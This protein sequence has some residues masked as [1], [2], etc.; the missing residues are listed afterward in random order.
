MVGKVSAPLSSTSEATTR[1][2][3]ELYH[4]FAAAAAERGFN[5]LVVEGPGQVGALHRNP[6]LVMRPDYEVPIS[7]VVDYLVTRPDVDPERLAIVGYP[8]GGYLAPRAAAFAELTIGV[9]QAEGWHLQQPAPGVLQ[10][11]TPCGRMLRHRRGVF[12]SPVREN[13]SAHRH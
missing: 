11:T 2:P 12:G 1:P 10:W 7:A 3:E 9:K 8:V 5:V 4:W 13:R 6:G